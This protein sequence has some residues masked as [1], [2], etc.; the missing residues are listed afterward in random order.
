M[1]F[2]QQLLG[3][4]GNQFQTNGAWVPITPEKPIQ[5]RSNTASDWQADQMRRA[6]YQEFPV[7]GRDYMN[8]TLM[9]YHGAYQNPHPIAQ[10]G[11]IGEYN[12]FGGISVNRNNVGN[13]IAGSYNQAQH[14]ESNGFNNKT[15]ELLL[16]KNA[17]GIATA[18]MNL[19]TSISMAAS[20]PL[21]P[22]FY[23]QSSSDASYSYTASNMVYTEAN[24]LLTPNRN[25]EFSGSN[26]DNLVNNNI[27]CPVSNQLNGIFSEV[28][29]GKFFSS[30]FQIQIYIRV[31]T[32]SF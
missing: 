24:K 28:S 2:G 23:P 25:F 1:N 7:P 15:L 27:H 16:K 8:E 21:L 5:I 3:Q 11:Q 4:D 22:K 26:T 19:D 30:V 17:T 29:Y 14:Y 13:H 32:M 6:N 10:T 20:N 31:L 9:H 12:N 18:N